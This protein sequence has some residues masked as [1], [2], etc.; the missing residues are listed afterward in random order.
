MCIFILDYHFLGFTSE[1]LADVTNERQL[2]VGVSLN[3]LCIFTEPSAN[4]RDHLVSNRACHT[5]CIH[6]L[7][8]TIS[9]A[10]TGS[11]EFSIN[12]DGNEQLY[13]TNT[14]KW[15]AVTALGWGVS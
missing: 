5:W 3:I 7:L 1:K 15:K 6:K 9:S 11:K 13:A 8:S 12:W 2:C 14:D 4:R 10:G